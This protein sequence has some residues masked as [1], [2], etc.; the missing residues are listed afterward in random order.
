[1][2]RRL[3]MSREMLRGRRQRGIWIRVVQ[4]AALTL[5]ALLCGGCAARHGGSATSTAA[6]PGQA[7][8]DEV[9]PLSAARRTEIAGLPQ[10]G[11]DY[12][13]AVDKLRAVYASL[14]REKRQQVADQDGYYFHT[15]E[16]PPSQARTIETVATA[17][18]MIHHNINLNL[19]ADREGPV[20]F[21]KATFGYRR[22]HGEIYFVVKTETK[23]ARFHMDYGP[24]GSW[25]GQ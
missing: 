23:T 21:T 15:A 9:V 10:N 17:T 24:I 1:M 18:P 11:P 3:T 16:L 5:A 22:D 19:Q 8:P 6:A 7:G 20:D 25:T 2:R 13:K 12:L 14:P 4:V